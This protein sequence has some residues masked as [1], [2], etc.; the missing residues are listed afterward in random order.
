MINTDCDKKSLFNKEITYKS[1]VL[2]K[3]VKM[4]SEKRIDVLNLNNLDGKKLKDVAKEI[5]ITTS[6]KSN[7]ALLE[8]IKAVTRIFLAGQGKND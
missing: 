6:K 7:V 2:E 4:V 8:E 3:L 1:D 5:G